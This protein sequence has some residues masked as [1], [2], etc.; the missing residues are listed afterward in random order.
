MTASAELESSE[1][2]AGKCAKSELSK[3][4]YLPGPGGGGRG[5]AEG[6]VV[7]W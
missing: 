7:S 6:L 3:V 5:G 2:R 1:H 4:P